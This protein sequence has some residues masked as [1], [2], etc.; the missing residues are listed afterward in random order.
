ML[1]IFWYITDFRYG[2][3]VELST[4]ENEV[5][6]IASDSQSIGRNIVG[7]PLNLGKFTS[8]MNIVH[9]CPEVL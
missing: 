7:F 9:V 3:E 8:D 6:L 2:D 4:P 1:C 5:L